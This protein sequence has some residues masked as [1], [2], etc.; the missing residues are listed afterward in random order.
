MGEYGALPKYLY[1]Q[2]EYLPLIWP[3]NAPAFYPPKN[4]TY[5]GAHLFQ[6]GGCCDFAFFVLKDHPHGDMKEE[7]KKK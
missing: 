5:L 3:R 6:N 1:Y 4:N 2:P 7:W